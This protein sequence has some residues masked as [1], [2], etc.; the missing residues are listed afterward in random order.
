M[1]EFLNNLS[2]VIWGPA[3]IALLLLSGVIL[4]FKTGFI[5]IRGFKRAFCLTLK[6]DSGSGE[7]SAFA[8][9]CTSLSAT[10]GTGNIIGVAVAVYTGG[11]GALFWM[12]ISAFFG[13]ATK[14]SEGLLAIK[15][16]K[17]D[18]AG[19]VIGGPF[20]YIEQAFKNTFKGN[21]IGRILAIAFSIFTVLAALLGIGTIT[22]SNSIYL[23]AQKLMGESDIN[24][25]F[26]V[27][28]LLAVFSGLI[29][30]GGAKLIAKV[31][32]IIVPFM[33]AFYLLF[34][35][36]IIFFNIENF[37]PSLKLI[38]TS[39]FDTSSLLGAATGITLRE[40]V[41]IGISRGIFSN[42]SG[43]GS[44]PIA[45]ASA[46]TDSAVNGGL[47]TM[48]GTFIDTFVVCLLTGISIITTNS[49]IPSADDGFAVTS[50]AFETGL[51]F[52]GNICVIILC[53]CLIFFAFTTIIGWNFYAEKCLYYLAGKDD[54][55]L[56]FLFRL[57][58]ILAIS[59]GP[60][61]NANAS[62]IIADIFNGL[63]CIPNITALLIL[64][65][66]V[67][68]ETKLSIN[69]C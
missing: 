5:Q 45:A 62:L 69:R 40:V 8:A 23:A 37:L 14:Y 53:I 10:L 25:S 17:V 35:L 36:I 41:K 60:F 20:Y 66:T 4:S 63:M 12:L 38:I 15:Y 59:V 61:M 18:S 11:P 22:Q 7:V 9:L 47:V 52:K 19:N 42:E 56:I 54:R 57:L 13:M 43:L 6:N 68:H 67:K 3:T 29:I 58:Y 30:F 64:S 2:S 44:A 33:A 48:T 16:R 28:L 32:E 1:S 21:R 49:H 65:N 50:R 26:A 31:S 51:P 34:S 46:K 24:I 27:S 55:K 39:A